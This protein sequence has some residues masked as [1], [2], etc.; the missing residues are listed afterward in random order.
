MADKRFLY[1]NTLKQSDMFICA[2]PPG[3]KS[4]LA[5]YDAFNLTSNR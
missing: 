5:L 3:E 2:G 4:G 1:S